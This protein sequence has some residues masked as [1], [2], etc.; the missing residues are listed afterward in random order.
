MKIIFEVP[1]EHSPFMLQLLQ[2]ISYVKN[3]RPKAATKAAKTSKPDPNGDATYPLASSINAERLKVAYEYFDRREGVF[4][5]DEES[6]P[7][8]K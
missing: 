6:H 7:I 1:Q 8:D 4:W 5:T 2:S 3:V